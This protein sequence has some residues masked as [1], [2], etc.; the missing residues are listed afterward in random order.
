[1]QQE[2][3]RRMC[4]RLGNEVLRPAKRGKIIARRLHAHDAFP[5]AHRLVAEPQP[6]LVAP[7]G[8][9]RSHTPVVPLVT[10]STRITTAKPHPRKTG[11]RV[12]QRPP[13]IQPAAAQM[14][15]GCMLAM[16][17]VVLAAVILIIVA[18]PMV[19]A[20]APAVQRRAVRMAILVFMRMARQPV[21]VLA[22]RI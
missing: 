12:T 8:Q 21:V 7:A 17:M 9:R 10:P 3:A 14:R 1:F 11:N 22:V 5:A 19:M 13:N 20:M 4:A 16:F 6:P 2:E 18:V 15:G